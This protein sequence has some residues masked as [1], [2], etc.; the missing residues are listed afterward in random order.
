MKT[1]Q[2]LLTLPLLLITARIAAASAVLI[3]E[4]CTST[5]GLP[6]CFPHDG[7]IDWGL[8]PGIGNFINNAGHGLPTPFTAPV[9]GVPGL[10]FTMSADPSVTVY[11]SG[12]C[13]LIPL[14]TS[15]PTDCGGVESWARWSTDSPIADFDFSQP[16]RSVGLV[17]T[18]RPGLVFELE[19]FNSQGVLIDS[20]VRPA[21][22]TD[23]FIGIARAES[24]ISRLR[25]DTGISGHLEYGTGSIQVDSGEVPEPA[26][27]VVAGFGVAVIA[28]LRR[29]RR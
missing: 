8:V 15:L 25:L 4:A 11:A 20:A 6:T 12:G 5:L 16:V 13:P 17:T 24:D 2:L 7:L 3:P 1:R 22:S 19:A 10:T 29:A 18:L 28:F 27:F 21:F 26:T 14:G 23:F 9:S